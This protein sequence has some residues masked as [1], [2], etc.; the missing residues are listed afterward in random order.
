MELTRKLTA[1]VRDAFPRFRRHPLFEKALRRVNSA[2]V[3]GAAF[4]LGRPRHSREHLIVEHPRM[5]RHS[6]RALGGVNR[7][8]SLPSTP[9]TSP[10][11]SSPMLQPSSPLSP[12]VL[13]PSDE[14]AAEKRNSEGLRRDSRLLRL[15]LQLA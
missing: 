6:Q 3:E 8:S 14:L 13:E 7:P 15:Q 10:T 4:G 9:G 2:H 12:M 11:H 1:A 5:R